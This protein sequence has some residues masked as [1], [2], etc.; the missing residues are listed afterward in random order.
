MGGDLSKQ[1]TPE[2]QTE[3]APPAEIPDEPRAIKNLLDEPI[4][5]RLK[6]GKY[7]F[8]GDVA[9]KYLSSV[10]MT[11][12]EL[13]TPPYNWTSNGQAD[14]VA[15]AVKTWG[16]EMGA[17]NFCHWFQPMG[18]SGLRHGQTGQVQLSMLSFKDGRV[19]KE[20][21]VRYFCC[22]LLL[23]LLFFFWFFFGFCFV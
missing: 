20:L 15:D 8:T 9:D 16:L 17:T 3:N 7:L 10:G 5:V 18:S 11:A 23:L 13:Q 2:V 22:F 14:K 4:D 1:V 6:F 12:R 19:V 21:K